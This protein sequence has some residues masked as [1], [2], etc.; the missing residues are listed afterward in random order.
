MGGGGANSLNSPNSAENS[1][2]DGDNNDTNITWT[3]PT[4]KTYEDYFI[5]YNITAET[6]TENDLTGN[7]TA[8]NPYIVH[9]TKGFLWLAK[10][11]IVG[12]YAKLECDVVLNDETFDKNGIPIGG[13]GVVYNWRPFY[14]LNGW[15]DGNHHSI[16]GYYIKDETRDSAGFFTKNVV[17]EVCNLTITNFYNEG[18]SRVFGMGI[19]IEIISNC[20]VKNGFVKS[21]NNYAS[22][23]VYNTKKIT[24]STNYA[25]IS[26][27]G[28]HSSAF[29]SSWANYTATLEKCQNYGHITGDTYVAGLVANPSGY[30]KFVNCQNFGKVEGGYAGGIAAAVTGGVKTIIGCSNFGDIIPKHGTT[31]GGILGFAYE[32]AVIENCYNESVFGNVLNVGNGGLVG[33]IS[34]PSGGYGGGDV[35]IRNCRVK[36]YNQHKRFRGIVGHIA[37][38]GILNMKN[39]YCEVE[40][41]EDDFYAVGNILQNA[42]I[43]IEGLEVDVKNIKILG[44]KIALFESINSAVT[45]NNA[46]VRGNCGFE[47]CYRSYAQHYVNSLVV[48]TNSQTYYGSDFSGFYIDYKTGEIGLKALSGKGFYQGKV[49]EEWLESKGFEKKVI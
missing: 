32:K 38:G 24:N 17:N 28:W 36:I 1:D 13:D 30:I 45:L 22:G 34:K 20:V 33:L 8:T 18:K 40:N 12:K 11:A 31:C 7:G 21:Q 5:D 29:I 47:F 49:T 26:A 41:M 27:I 44:K 35:Y 43:E 37:E 2:F 23:F 15:F 25:D 10:I 4:Y 14:A 3:E 9:S 39:V 48:N 46:L 6:I 16:S 19:H 42:Q